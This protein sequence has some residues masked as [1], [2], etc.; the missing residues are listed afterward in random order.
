MI[1]SQAQAAGSH[2]IEWTGLDASDTTGKKTII[3][4]EGDYT[5]VIQATNPVSGTQLNC[6][7]E[8]EN[9]LLI[10]IALTFI[11]VHRG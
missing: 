9:N 3:S 8:S 7:G 6:K 10:N 4:E 11:P 5:V 1:D 2:E